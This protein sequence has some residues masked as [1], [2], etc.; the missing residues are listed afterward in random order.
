MK[1]TSH[2]VSQVKTD[3]QQHTIVYNQK[4]ESTLKHLRKITS[5]VNFQDA[6]C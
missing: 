5:V 2:G 4:H 3:F 6:D 1:K